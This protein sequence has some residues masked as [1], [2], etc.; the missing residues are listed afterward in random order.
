[1][2]QYK[3]TGLFCS[4]EGHVYCLDVSCIGFLQAF[5]LLT[6]D[7]I[8]LGRHYQL[9]TITDEKGNVRKIDDII[10]CGALIS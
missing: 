6:A 3:Y 8:R 7:A 4:K 1:M 2:K 9:E 10:K 5:F